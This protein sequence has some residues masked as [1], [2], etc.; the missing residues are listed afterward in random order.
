MIVAALYVRDVSHYKDMPHVEAYDRHRDARTYPG[1]YPV[2]AHP[3]CR[4]WGKYAHWS[5]AE[6]EERD[7]AFLALDQVRRFGGVLEHPVGSRLWP[8]MQLPRPGAVH[9][10]FG[11]WTLQTDQ[12]R[13]GH[14]AMKPTLLY[15]VGLQPDQLPPLPPARRPE[16][17]VENM[18]RPERE[19]TPEPFARFLV[20][21][22]RRCP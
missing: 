13:F 4:S 20:D 1:P 2:V 22:A 16:T 18:G 11:G 6:T 5:K 12:C 15:I 19:R 17:T 9:D 7:L 8:V 21:L 10:R 14:R 3:P